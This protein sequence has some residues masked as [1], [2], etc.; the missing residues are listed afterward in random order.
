[1]PQ[2]PDIPPGSPIGAGL[3][4]WVSESCWHCR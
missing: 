4:F 2:A 3:Q 1:M